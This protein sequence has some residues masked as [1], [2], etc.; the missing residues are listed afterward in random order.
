MRRL[1]LTFVVVL[2][3]LSGKPASAYTTLLAFG[4]SLSDAG[5]IFISNKGTLPLYPRAVQF[6]ERPSILRMMA[7]SRAASQRVFRTLS[8]PLARM[9]L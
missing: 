5:N 2:L 1:G 7:R 9:M 6:S 4:D 3:A 8:P